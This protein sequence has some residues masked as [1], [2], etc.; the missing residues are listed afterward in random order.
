MEYQKLLSFLDNTTNQLFKFSSKKWVEISYDARGAYNTNI[1]NE[2]KIAMSESSLCDCTDVYIRI[3]VTITD[4]GQCA[5]AVAI[6][7]HRNDKEALFKNCALFL[8]YMSKVIN[9]EVDKT[10]D[11]DVYN[12]NYSKTSG[13]LRKKCRHNLQITRW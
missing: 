7:G 4:V 6:E 2:F 8:E 5:N 3:K 11:L 10:K 9:T 12:K 1:P 13:T